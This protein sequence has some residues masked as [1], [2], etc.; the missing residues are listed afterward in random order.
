MD[1]SLGAPRQ[2]HI[3]QTFTVI[4]GPR[5]GPGHGSQESYFQDVTL[6]LFGC[7]CSVHTPWYLELMVW[8]PHRVTS[9]KV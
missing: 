3:L 7:E 4:S 8:Q 9:G 1:V 2:G 5:L 6:L